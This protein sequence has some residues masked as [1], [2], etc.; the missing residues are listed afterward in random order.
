MKYTHTA[1]L[2]HLVN[3]VLKSNIGVLQVRCRLVHLKAME[4]EVVSGYTVSAV[5][6]KNSIEVFKP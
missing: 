3:S 4:G 2:N 6:N 5:Q 1:Q